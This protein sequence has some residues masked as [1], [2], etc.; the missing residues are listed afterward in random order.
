MHILF[1][2]VF[3]PCALLLCISYPRAGWL[4]AF[5]RKATMLARLPLRLPL[6]PQDFLAG[7]GMMSVD[8]FLDIDQMSYGALFVD[9]GVCC[10]HQRR[11]YPPRTRCQPVPHH[12]IA[13]NGPLALS[14][15]LWL[16]AC[17]VTV[18]GCVGQPHVRLVIDIC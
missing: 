1:V 16:L 3:S 4:I 2:V 6:H 9:S 17:M 14:G 15:T 7:L 12:P 18:R 10:D 8:R 11:F 5:A 13:S